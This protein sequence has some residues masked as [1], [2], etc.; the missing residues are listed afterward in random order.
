MIYINVNPTETPA[1]CFTEVERHPKI[2]M[3]SKTA[4]NNQPKQP[5]NKQAIV[6]GAND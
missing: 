5:C 2:Y 4:L 6:E 3:E 1:P